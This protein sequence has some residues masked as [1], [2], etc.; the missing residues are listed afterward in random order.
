MHHRIQLAAGDM[1][2]RGWKPTLSLITPPTHTHT[3]TQLLN[4]GEKVDCATNVYIWQS[5]I[6]PLKEIVESLFLSYDVMHTV[7]SCWCSQCMLEMNIEF[8]FF[9]VLLSEPVSS[10]VAEIVTLIAQIVTLIPWSKVCLYEL[11]VY[12]W[13]RYRSTLIQTRLNANILNNRY[14][15]FILWVVF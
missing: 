12:T 10:G 15:M 5:L 13:Y 8:D 6:L 1:I 3:H 14:T 9:Q 4:G 11:H 2:L 7:K